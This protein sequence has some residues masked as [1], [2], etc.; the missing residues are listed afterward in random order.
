MGRKWQGGEIKKE[1]QAKVETSKMNQAWGRQLYH[2]GKLQHLTPSELSRKAV[3]DAQAQL[4]TALTE[5][6]MLA[7]TIRFSPHS[8]GQAPGVVCET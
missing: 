6:S 1:E 8:V 5:T 7:Q 3:H 2:V 4:A